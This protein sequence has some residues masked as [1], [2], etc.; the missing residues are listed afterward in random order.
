MVGAQAYHE[1]QAGAS[2]GM[3]LNAIASLAIDISYGEMKSSR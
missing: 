1:Y 2:C 3:D